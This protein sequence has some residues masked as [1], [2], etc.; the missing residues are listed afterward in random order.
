MQVLKYYRKLKEILEEYV[1]FPG[2]FSLPSQLPIIG[3]D[4][5]MDSSFANSPE[6][7][8]FENPANP[9]LQSKRDRD[10]PVLWQILPFLVSRR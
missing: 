9:K 6:N 7:D 1:V 4:L 3:L 2:W 5:E 8:R 10:V